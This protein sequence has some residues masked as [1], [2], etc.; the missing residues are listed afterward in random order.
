MCMYSADNGH[1]TD[2]HLVHLGAFAYR[3]ASLTIIEASAVLPN[4]RI[5]PQDAGLW[6]DSQIAPIKRIADFLHSQNQKLGI[7]LAHAGRKASACAPWL[8]ERGKAVTA[9]EDVGG[10]PNNVMGASAIKWGEGFA[11]PREMTGQDIQDVINGFR[12]SAKRALEAGVDV[13]EIHA[14]HGYLLSSFLSP[15]SNRRTDNYGGSFENRIRLLLEVIKAIREVIPKGMPLLV[16]VSSTEWMDKQ[17]S[18]SWDVESTIR[19]AKLLPALGV[20]LL[21]VSSGGNNEKQAMTP[22][23]DFQIGIA[24]RIREELHESGIK[25]LLIGAVGMITEAEAAKAIV[26]NGNAGKKDETV[27]IEDEQ[28]ARAKADI[29]LVARQFLREPEWVLRVAYRLGVKVQW[30]QQYHRGHFVRGSRI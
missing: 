2:F 24:G 8:V 17:V 14:A 12:D 28:G 4:G 20:D 7:Q 22:Y 3:G 6:T 18:E 15:I 13:I 1:L 25:D 23:N 10:W 27:E 29:V 11:N 30:P 9:T 5:T 26:E 19:L 21:D 16:R